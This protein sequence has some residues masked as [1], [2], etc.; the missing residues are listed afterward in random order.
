MRTVYARIEKPLRTIGQLAFALLLAL[1]MVVAAPSEK[2]YASVDSYID[3]VVDTY[4]IFTSTSGAGYTSPKYGFT[5]RQL[6]FRNSYAITGYTWLSS[7][8]VQY[9]DGNI[10][11]TGTENK[12]K[13]I[14]DTW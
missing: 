11:H 3:D 8:T 5:Y 1:T 7:K 2:A 6:T 9:T 13:Y 4:K 12:Y 14:Y 10:T